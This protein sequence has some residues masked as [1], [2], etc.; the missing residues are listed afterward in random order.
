MKLYMRIRHILYII[1][2]NIKKFVAIIYLKI[3]NFIV[4]EIESEKFSISETLAT[5]RTHIAIIIGLFGF[6]FLFISMRFQEQMPNL[7]YIFSAEIGKIL[8]TA[9]IFVWIIER[10]TIN[11]LLTKEISISIIRDL[12][13]YY[14]N[15]E[16]MKNLIVKFTRELNQY[17]TIDEDIW[18]LY[19]RHGIIELFNEPIRE[20][21]HINFKYIGCATEFKNSIIVNK[22]WTYRAKNTA[23]KISKG[24]SKR[25]NGNGLIHGAQTLVDESFPCDK[26][27]IKEFI[28]NEVNFLFYKTLS[29][30]EGIIEK[31]RLEP[32]YFHRKDFND[33][34]GL[35]KN[36]KL[37]DSDLT[38]PNLFLVFDIDDYSRIDKKKY[39]IMNIYLTE[40]I[41]P[42]SGLGIEFRY[43]AIVKDFNISTFDFQSYTCGFSFSLECFDK[44]KT[45]VG[46]RIIGK[47]FVSNKTDKSMTYSGWILPHSSISCAWSR[48]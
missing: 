17:E 44:F 10:Y 21:L 34:I 29:S 13:R 47:G 45:D 9:G 28:Q 1:Y 11:K 41:P 35:P 46:E 5:S 36:S 43:N 30:A 27:K 39:L 42:G 2:L 24:E 16:E 4:I 12:F 14:F 3:K 23:K 7:L 6:I 15:K 22:Q 48:K 20:D 32:T 8:I 26:V 37:I 31:K 40:K 18:E 38:D 25:I 19:E 33:E